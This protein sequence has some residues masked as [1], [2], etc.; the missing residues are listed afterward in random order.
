ML[1]IACD[2]V[3]CDVRKFISSKHKLLKLCWF[4][5]LKKGII[6]NFRRGFKTQSKNRAIVLPD[7]ITDKK[8]AGALVGK[9]VVWET[10]AKKEKNLLK[11]RIVKEHGGKGAV[12]V[13]FERGLPG[14]II[15]EKVQIE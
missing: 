14:Q 1:I 8:Q 2:F 3:V 9:S 4:P 6:V 5:F 7:G 12:M 15:G 13:V 10:P 11:G